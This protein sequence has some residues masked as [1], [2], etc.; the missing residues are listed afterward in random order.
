MDIDKSVNFAP[1]SP[2]SF[3]ERNQWVYKNKEAIMYGLQKYTYGEFSDRVQRC[4]SALK[5]A[6]IQSGDRVAYL[7][8]NIPPML[9]AHFAVPL[10]GAILVAMNTRLS[11]DEIAYICDH[12]GAKVLVADT[13]LAIPLD[14]HKEKFSKIETFINVIDEQA[15][16]REKDAIFQGPEYESFINSSENNQLPWKIEDELTPISINYTSGTTGKPKGV[17][18]T[19]R[20]AYLNALSGI[21][22]A[23]GSVYMNYLWTLP[24]FH[25][26]GWCYPWGVTSVGGRHIC[27]R[28]NEP[29]EIF[30]LIREEK[31]SHFCAAPT[32]LTGLSNDPAAKDGPFPQPVT[33][34]TG[35][36]PPSPTI[37]STIEEELGGTIVHVYGLTETYGPHTV[38]TWNPD[39]DTLNNED[40]AH[41]KSRQGVPF[42][43]TGECDVKDD[44]MKSVPWDKKTQGE[45]MMRGNTVMAG[46]YENPEATEEAFRGGWFHS[47][48]IAIT[49][50]DGY[51]DLQDRAK[52]I[53]ISGGENISTIEIEKAIS[54]HQSVL[55]VAVVAVPDDKWGEVPKAFIVKKNN[56]KVTSEEI[57]EHVKSKIARFK[58]PKYVEFGELPKTS[59]GKIQKYKLRDQE[60]A[61]REKRVN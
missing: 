11:P 53:I 28:T 32:V 27:L 3:L 12:S 61:G 17:M 59:T 2:L 26:N 44:E 25:C 35:G 37:I 38:C 42:V 46:Y 22:E 50:E 39:W 10:L 24:M 60:W 29:T 5:N 52:D 58:A 57:I 43:I 49:Y 34:M 6:G 9:E 54:S 36:A 48:D 8:P 18:Y 7:C 16:F 23:K 13:E 4:A 41:L 51:I 33:V 56:A 1:L 15:G 14:S 55:E 31:V 47:G 30:R 40:R 45:V 21:L 20:G 19:H